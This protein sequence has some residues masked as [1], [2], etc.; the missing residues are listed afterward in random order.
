MYIRPQ[1]L[2]G[3]NGDERGQEQAKNECSNNWLR[4]IA[5]EG[6]LMGFKAVD[7]SLFRLAGLCGR[8]TAHYKHYLESSRLYH[9]CLKDSDHQPVTV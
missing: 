9:A 5:G 2:T 6:R 3:C 1:G 4:C 7:L 8:G